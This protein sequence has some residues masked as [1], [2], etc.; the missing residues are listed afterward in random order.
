M[1]INYV[2]HRKFVEKLL[3]ER[4]QCLAPENSRT[5]FID[6]RNLRDPQRG[7]CGASKKHTGRN[8]RMMENTIDS[9]DMPVVMQD[10]MKAAYD[11]I[12]FKGKS[13]KHLSLV[14]CFVCREG[15]HRSEAPRLC[16]VPAVEKLGGVV[17]DSQPL[18]CR[19]CVKYDDPMACKYCNP[20]NWDEEDFDIYLNCVLTC[21]K[22]NAG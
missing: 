12:K 17:F 22:H 11:T 1:R 2:P 8:T 10:F 13:T 3:K 16:T 15:T 7:G 14:L 19:N 21:T 4:F 5:Y 9:D 6:T 20:D 18:T